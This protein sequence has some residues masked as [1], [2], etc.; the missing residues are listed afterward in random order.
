[1]L[2]TRS[3]AASVLAGV[4]TALNVAA[5]TALASVYNNVPQRTSYPY[6]AIGFVSEERD[7]AMGMN[8]KTVLV[9]VTV[10]SQAAGDL[11]AL[12]IIDK[13]VQLLNYQSITVANHTLVSVQ[14]GPGFDQTQ[15]DQ[16]VAGVRTRQQT[17]YFRVDVRQSA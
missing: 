6:V 14:Y 11:E 10:F 13:V 15:S 8:G 5:L 12:T 1:M 17:G 3:A 2:T 9:S 16:L 7:D 4:Y